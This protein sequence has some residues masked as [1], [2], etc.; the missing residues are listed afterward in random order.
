M[1]KL[2]VDVP[3][4]IREWAGKKTALEMAMDLDISKSTIVSHAIALDISLVLDSVAEE[5]RKIDEAIK[6]YA[7]SKTVPEIARLINVPHHRIRSRGY[8]RGIKFK[9]T[10][11]TLTKSK[12]DKIESSEVY[13]REH[14]R[15]NWLI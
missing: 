5:N 1:I 4:Y 6:K 10:Y 11:T 2:K 9:S 15:K 12:S 3:A 7:D 14:S 13:F 8:W